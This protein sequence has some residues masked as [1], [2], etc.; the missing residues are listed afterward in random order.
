M[1]DTIINMDYLLVDKL[2][3]DQLE[4]GDFIEVDDEIVSVIEVS[5]DSTGDYYIVSFENE[6]GEKDV[7]KF[8]YT[9]AIK[10]FIL[11]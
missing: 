2:T 5:D 10:L 9:D 3:P 8:F 7:T 4:S 11:Q 6:F 1:S